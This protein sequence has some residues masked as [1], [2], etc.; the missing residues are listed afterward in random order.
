[1][2]DYIN[3]NYTISFYSSSIG[4]ERKVIKTTTSTGES[5]KTI[6][7]TS[8]FGMSEYGTAPS[9][10]I[11]RFSDGSSNHDFTAIHDGEGATGSYGTANQFAAGTN[12]PANFVVDE[13]VTKLNASSLNLTASAVAGNSSTNAGL[14]V[15]PVSDATVTITE[16]PNNANSG[17]FGATAGFAVI[18]DTSTESS[19]ETRTFFAPFRFSAKGAFN[20]RNQ[21]SL[22]SYK[23]FVGDQ[24]T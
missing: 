6:T 21:S 18:T 5:S 7:F 15:V 2:S 1:M 4:D 23:T 20:L 22:N 11:L 9:S 17:N 16:D 8:H 12:R 24:N 3:N 14:K 10:V 19:S 13:M